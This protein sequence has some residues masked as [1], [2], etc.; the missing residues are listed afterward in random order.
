MVYTL[1]INLFC[2][3][4][5]DSLPMPDT[6][7]SSVSSLSSES[8]LTP[9]EIWAHDAEEITDHPSD[10]E[11]PEWIGR[12]EPTPQLLVAYANDTIKI[13][14]NDDCRVSYSCC[15]CDKTHR[16]SWSRKDEKFDPTSVEF[17][18]GSPA[19]RYVIA[20]CTIPVN[21]ATTAIKLSFHRWQMRGAKAIFVPGA[22][23]AGVA[24]AEAGG[25][26]A[27]VSTPVQQSRKRRAVEE[28]GAPPRARGP[29]FVSESTDGVSQR[30]SA[31][32]DNW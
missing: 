5:E 3:E 13:Y 29:S 21:R 2:E 1:S 14:P 15:L 17:K 26:A 10:D 22:A 18:L 11:A 7:Q 25:A 9:T 23:A 20:P 28:P 27:V 16:L 8:S 32:F 31:R 4:T 6:P 30:L 24:E 19:V 12:S